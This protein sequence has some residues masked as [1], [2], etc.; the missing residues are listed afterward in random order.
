MVAQLSSSF[1]TLPTVSRDAAQVGGARR[2]RSRV[3]VPNTNGRVGVGIRLR[4]LAR[5]TRS[6][7]PIAWRSRS[8][9]EDAL[10]TRFGVP[11]SILACKL[12]LPGPLLE[13]V[14]RAHERGEP[15][16]EV[17][18]SSPQP[19]SVVNPVNEPA[20]ERRVVAWRS[21]G[22]LVSPAESGQRIVVSL[23]PPVLG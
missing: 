5:R 4:S 2:F 14:G 3:G 12:A 10:Q 6:A 15:I 17:G 21:V 22:G 16:E 23:M 20:T 7:R 11:A 18:D 13:R 19:R 8:P 1:R 9:V